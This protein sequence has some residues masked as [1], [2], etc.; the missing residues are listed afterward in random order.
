MEILTIECKNKKKIEII[1]R[2]EK[3]WWLKKYNIKNSVHSI[4]EVEEYIFSCKIYN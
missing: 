1:N 3:I 2:L 4:I